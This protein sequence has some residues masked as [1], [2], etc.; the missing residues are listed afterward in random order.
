MELDG[1]QD[2]MLS[3]KKGYGEAL[4]ARYALRWERGSEY[5]N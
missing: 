2:I 5:A 4:P 3:L 1:H